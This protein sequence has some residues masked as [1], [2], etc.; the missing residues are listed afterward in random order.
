MENPAET[1]DILVH[2]GFHKTGT[3]T[4]QTFL[5]VNRKA[6]EMYFFSYGKTDFAGVGA[7]DRRYGQ[8]PYPWRLRHF[9]RGLRAFLQTI[10][11]G[12]RIVLSRE[13]FSGIMPGHQ[14]LFGTVRS[15][16][17]AAPAL[18]QA[19]MAEPRHRFGPAVK[20]KFLYT[21][22]DR[23]SWLRS[24]YGH[25]L[26]SIRV[27]EDFRRFTDNFSKEPLSEEADQVR[28]AL[29]GIPVHNAP[30]EKYS[31]A[32]AGPATCVLDIMG[33]P[34]NLY[35]EL[36]QVGRV[37]PGDRLQVSEEFLALNRKLRNKQTLKA[38]KEEI[39]ARERKSNG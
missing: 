29:G 3:S 5:Q 11:D 18:S 16:S 14:R 9:C 20:V 19:I 25:L 17:R 15:Y 2:A 32:A 21:T 36:K 26:R 8:R 12:Q 39:L 7:R 37:N 6:L 13:T 34:P 22:R 30:L 10:P 24:V 27:R 4:L 38:A 28:A 23:A 31:R 1:P 33:V 35:S